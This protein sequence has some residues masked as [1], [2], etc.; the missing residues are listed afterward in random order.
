M[1]FALLLFN[2]CGGWHGD[3]Y[4][5]TI[6]Q[7]I[8]KHYKRNA[9]NSFLQLLTFNLH[10]LCKQNMFVL[11]YLSEAEVMRRWAPTVGATHTAKN[12]KLRLQ[13]TRA[14]R[15]WTT[16][17][18]KN[19]ACDFCCNILMAGSPPSCFVSVV[20]VGGVGV[21]MLRLFSWHTHRHCLN[22]TA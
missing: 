6:Y 16:E 14:H 3:W 13:V 2:C 8:S 15:T 20:L 7:Q 18:C 1:K 21:M 10:V 22:T 11:R 4:Q 19:I 12:R 5:S 17:N 9:H